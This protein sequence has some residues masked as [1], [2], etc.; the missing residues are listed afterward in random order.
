MLLSLL[1]ISCIIVITVV[2]GEVVVMIQWSLSSSANIASKPK[3]ATIWFS[4]KLATAPNTLIIALDTSSVRLKIDFPDSISSH[5]RRT[6]SNRSAD[7]HCD[8]QRNI[9]LLLSS[10]F[11]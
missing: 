11:V 5:A 2:I 6:T 4:I 8:A 10:V 1:L 7:E 9:I 3:Q